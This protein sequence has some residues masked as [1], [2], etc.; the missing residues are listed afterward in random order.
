MPEFT[1]AF[2]EITDEEVVEVKMEEVRGKKE[3]I[4]KQRGGVYKGLKAVKIVGV[5]GENYVVGM[6]A[7]EYEAVDSCLLVALGED[8]N[9]VSFESLKGTLKVEE[10]HQVIKFAKA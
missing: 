6:T 8:N 9:V 4:Q 5:L 10:L 1:V 3:E 7:E 2:N